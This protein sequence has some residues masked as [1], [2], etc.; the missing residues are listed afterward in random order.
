[1]K[2]L[3]SLLLGI[4]LLPTALASEVTL[5]QKMLV[6]LESGSGF[7]AAYSL[8]LGSSEAED[9]QPLTGS[10]TYISDGVTEE[11]TLTDAD[12]NLLIKTNKGLDGHFVYLNAEVLSIV[13][14]G[15]KIDQQ[16]L[17]KAAEYLNLP[18]TMQILFA[19]LG[20]R[21][22]YQMETSLLAKERRDQV[23]QLLADAMDKYKSDI[24]LW[25]QKFLISKKNEVM[26]DGTQSLGLEYSVPVDDAKSYL[27]ELI[28][29]LA[30][31]AFLVEALKE[32]MPYEYASLLLHFS[33][34]KFIDLAIDALPLEGEIALGRTFSLKGK[35]ISTYMSLPL[36]D[37]KG[38]ACVVTYSVD[39]DEAAEEEVQH[40][41]FKQDKSSLQ[42]DYT[43]VTGD[44]STE[45]SGSLRIQSESAEKSHALKFSLTRSESTY[46]DEEG[47]NNQDLSL[48][49]K[50]SNDTGF[51]EKNTDY[52]A[53]DELEI[54]FS[55]KYNSGVAKNTSTHIDTELSLLNKNKKQLLEFSSK[56]KTAAPWAIEKLLIA[57]VSLLDFS[58]EKDYQSAMEKLAAVLLS[59]YP[60]AKKSPFYAFVIDT[61]NITSS[62]SIPLLEEDAEDA[63]ET[64]DAETSAEPAQSTA[65]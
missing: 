21:H 48:L 32:S 57:E 65:P 18:S 44:S 9:K 33:D 24:D 2:K 13:D 1:M 17:T 7:R 8:Y 55:Q 43:A 12:G 54:S 64:T 38:G 59:K 40:I 26:E 63:P 29:E 10:Y 14:D 20:Y 36:Y 19:V 4:L 45:Y 6:Q 3:I 50:I 46:V 51:L 37:A 16:L 42:I 49:A 28:A 22:E 62:S 15:K 56:G 52:S 23:A 58:L 11:R 34:K 30:Q 5:P 31:D 60:D 53:I 35:P 25:L 39:N 47:K 61:L 27:K 41:L